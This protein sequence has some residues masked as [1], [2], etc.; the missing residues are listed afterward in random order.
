MPRDELRHE[1]LDMLQ[2]VYVLMPRLLQ[3]L[4][5]DAAEARKVVEQMLDRA[6]LCRDRVRG[7]SPMPGRQSTDKPDLTLPRLRVV[8]V[9]DDAV[10]L[11]SLVEIIGRNHEVVGTA[12]TGPEM[13]RTVLNKTPDM[14]VFDVHLPGIDGLSA[15]REIFKEVALA[16]VVITGDR[17]SQLVERALEDL[18]LAYLLKPADAQ[19]IGAAIHIAWARFNEYD[20][21][22]SRNQSLQQ[23][24]EDRKAIERAKGLLMKWNNWGESQAFR[25]LQRTAMDRRTS[26]VMVAQE[27]I[28]GQNFK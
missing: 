26:M 17:N 15:L 1:V 6:Q 19:Q 14:V 25:T 27:V 24:L 12:T 11:S 3:L 10:E 13:V 8:V 21:L 2:T 7:P 4:P 9:E 28:R 22:Q 16:S 20:Q 23:N 5:P 18:I